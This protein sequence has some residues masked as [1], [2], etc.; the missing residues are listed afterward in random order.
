MILSNVI[1]QEENKEHIVEQYRFKVISSFSQPAPEKQIEQ[2]IKEDQPELVEETKD[3]APKASSEDTK[4][5]PSFIEEL[6]KRTEELSENIVKLQLQIENQE[7]EFKERLETEVN[8]TKEDALK[9]GESLAKAKFD[10]ELS[11][12]ET[13]YT[14]SIKKLDEEKD[15]LE[16][17]YQKSEK[18][19][20]NTAIDI[21]KEVIL[22]EIKDSSAAIASNIAKNLIGELENASQ[23]EI[24]TNPEDYEFV[25][26]NIKLSS[27]LKV[28]ADDAISKGGVIILSDIGNIDGSVAERFEKIKKILSE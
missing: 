21:A 15:K 17:L 8:R 14:N 7:K 28:S 4:L 20:A 24:K 27:N 25:K 22:K 18:E 16:K 10:A 9:E 26:E 12:I 3:E 1:N 6:L 2:P 23:I 11:E 13:K 5:E 19:I